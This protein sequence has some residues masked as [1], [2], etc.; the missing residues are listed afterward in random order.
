MNTLFT[1]EKRRALQETAGSKEARLLR[2]GEKAFTLARESEKTAADVSRFV[3]LTVGRQ[4][5]RYGFTEKELGQWL[6]GAYSSLWVKQSNLNPGL[7]AKD[8][9][10]LTFQAFK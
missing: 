10:K 5:K 9:R 3:A 4:A 7:D 1:E 8:V 2:W 6:Q